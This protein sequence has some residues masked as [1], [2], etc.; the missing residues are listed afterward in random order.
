VDA[1]LDVGARRLGHVE[2]L[3]GLF[4]DGEVLGEVA[5]GD[6]LELVVDGH[7][8]AAEAAAQR[9]EHAV[10]QIR[11]AVLEFKNPTA[12]ALLADRVVRLRLLLV[13]AALRERRGREQKKCGEQGE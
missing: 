8:R 6:G 1:E 9:A 12:E 13:V 2:A 7:R 11:V 5:H 4:D 10:E 3:D